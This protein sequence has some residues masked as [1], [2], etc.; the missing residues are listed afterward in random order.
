NSAWQKRGQD[1]AAVPRPTFR[2]KDRESIKCHIACAICFSQV[3]TVKFDK[4]LRIINRYNL[5][6]FFCAANM[7]P[8]FEVHAGHQAFEIIPTVDLERILMTYLETTVL[9]SQT[10]NQGQSI[11]GRWIDR[12]FKE[13]KG[14]QLIDQR[15]H[16]RETIH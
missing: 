9:K 13:I 16:G 7:L 2:E 4:Y 15:P 10:V 1:D 8:N 6:L 14:R 5:T 11:V 3:F 12:L